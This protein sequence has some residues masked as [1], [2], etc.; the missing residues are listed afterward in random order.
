M[1]QIHAP[2]SGRGSKPSLE[3]FLGWAL[4]LLLGALTLSPLFVKSESLRWLFAAES[5]ATAAVAAELEALR[6]EATARKQDI[7]SLRS[8]HFALVREC[9]AKVNDAQNGG[10][11][12]SRPDCV[13]GNEGT[14]ANENL[15]ANQLLVANAHVQDAH[16]AWRRIERVRRHLSLLEDRIESATERY[17]VARGASFEQRNSAATAVYNFWAYA[18]L[19]AVGALS[20]CLTLGMKV[21]APAGPIVYSPDR[22]TAPYVAASMF[23]GGVLAIAVVG[24]M[25]VPLETHGLDFRAAAWVILCSL[26]GDLSLAAAR[27]YIGRSYAR[28]LVSGDGQTAAAA[29][30]P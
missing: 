5:A 1:N 23:V 8:E 20:F 9:N 11:L 15:R 28:K 17:L 21:F 30:A 27:H 12:Q 25:Q 16:D 26:V 14:T 22:L 19:G 3:R 29:A 10:Q 4:L 2:C 7:K 13:N 6:A 24:L 18:A